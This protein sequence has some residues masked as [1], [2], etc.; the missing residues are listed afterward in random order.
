ME[1]NHILTGTEGLRK[2]YS[3]LRVLMPL[4]EKKE[5]ESMLYYLEEGR[6][7]MADLWELGERLRVWTQTAKLMEKFHIV[8]L[9]HKLHQY[10][11]M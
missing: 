8:S 9:L 5:I 6:G 2:Q 1:T 11:D 4:E 7:D 3:F 10:A